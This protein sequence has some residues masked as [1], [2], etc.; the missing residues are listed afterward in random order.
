M[1]RSTVYA[2]ILQDETQGY[3]QQ[4]RSYILVFCVRKPEHILL[5]IL[6]TFLLSSRWLLLFVSE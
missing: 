5:W 4:H 3:K 1:D 2:Y 6:Q